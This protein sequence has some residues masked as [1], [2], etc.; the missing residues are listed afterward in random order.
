MMYIKHLALCRH[1]VLVPPS[2][3][4]SNIARTEAEPNKICI[5][6]ALRQLLLGEIQ[7]KK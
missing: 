3:L 6:N 4:F 2:L 5:H 1:S 7:S